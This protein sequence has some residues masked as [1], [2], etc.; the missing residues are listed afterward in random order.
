MV[1]GVA[2]VGQVLAHGDRAEAASAAGRG[3]PI[4]ARADEILAEGAQVHLQVRGAVALGIDAHEHDPGARQRGIARCTCGQR[5]ERGRADIG[6]VGEAE[7]QQRRMAAQ[8]LE[9]EVQR[10]TDRSRWNAGSARGCGSQ[11]PLC[12]GTPVVP[13]MRAS[14]APTITAATPIAANSRSGTT[15]HAP[16]ITQRRGDAD[17]PGDCWR[18][19][20]RRLARA[21]LHYG[22]GTDNARDDAAALLWHVLRL[23]P[24]ATP[25]TVRA[26]RTGSAPGEALEALLRAAHP[27]AHA[28]GVSHASLLV[29]RSAELYVDQRVLIPR[30]PIAE[31]IER[32]FEPW[33]SRARVRRILD[34]GTG[35]GCIAIACARAFPRAR[36]STR[37]TSPRTRSRWRAGQHP[38]PSARAR[39]CAPCESDHFTALGGASYDIIVSNPPYVGRR[40]LRGPADRIPARAAAGA[41]GRQRRPGLGENHFARRGSASES[42][43][44]PDRRGG[45]FGRGAAARVSTTAVHSGWRSS[46][47][48]AACLCSSASSCSSMQDSGRTR[49]C[50]ATRIGRLFSVTTF[51]ESH[52][53]ALGCIVDGCP[54]GLALDARPI[55]SAT[56]IGV[57]PARRSS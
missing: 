35:S 49:Q 44:N 52:G 38:P 12:S 41:G 40:E 54:P 16:I 57:A 2:A 10:P 45:K 3:R 25:R 50:R 8:A 46:A 1:H 23:P 42:G 11:V 28:G 18:A 17:G 22:H 39:A 34:L 6:A 5:G 19:R 15:I 51:G 37:S 33:M 13:S 48:A 43:R 7:E 9:A 26:P 20:T 56:S 36:A 29:R 32:R 55:C 14:R 31:L 27:R 53:P 47:A 4:A 24:A 21:R 30:S